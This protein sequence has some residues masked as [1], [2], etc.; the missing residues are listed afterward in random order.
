[1]KPALNTND[2]AATLIRDLDAIAAAAREIKRVAR[3]AGRGEI[4][5]AD[6]PRFDAYLRNLLAVAASHSIGAAQHGD[7]ENSAEVDTMAAAL[8]NHYAPRTIKRRA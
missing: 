2:A 1:M 6:L 3:L 5:M 4:P 8:V 7:N